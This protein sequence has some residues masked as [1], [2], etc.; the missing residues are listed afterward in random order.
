MTQDTR[1]LHQRRGRAAE[2]N[3]IVSGIDPHEPTPDLLCIVGYG[4]EG[5]G[6]GNADEQ[7]A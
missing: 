7:K 5:E 3:T 2:E 4:Y 6:L 1:A